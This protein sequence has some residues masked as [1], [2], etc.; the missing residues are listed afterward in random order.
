M[1]KDI[2]NYQY[3]CSSLTSVQ[4]M[5]QAPVDQLKPIVLHADQYLATEPKSP[6]EYYRKQDS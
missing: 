4:Q 5:K 2:L 1:S 6:N 3:N